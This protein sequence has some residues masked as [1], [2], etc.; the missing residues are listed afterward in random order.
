MNVDG[1]VA[2]ILAQPLPKG[3]L[4]AALPMYDWPE[5][6]RDVDAQWAPLRDALRARGVD[7]P[8]Q[9]ARCN[10]DLPAYHGA[11]AD[12]DPH[13]FDLGALWRHPGLL[14][15][16]ACYGP[17]ELWAGHAV[18]VVGQQDYSGV[19]GG[20]GALYRSAI[21]MRAGAYERDLCE[22]PPSVL[23]DISPTGGE[24]DNLL[25]LLSGKRLAYNAPDSM[26]GYLA[27][28]RDLVAQGAGLDIFAEQ[29]VSGGHRNSIRMVA[30]GAADV[31]AVDAKTWG[32][33]LKHEPM[34]RE[35]IVVGWTE[36]R[37]GLPYVTRAATRV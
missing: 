9:L 2:A 28:E 33:A 24:I 27:I 37:P 17:I 32:L 1:I 21:V 10:A 15:A 6:R 14:F 25:T 12:L 19:E 31:A 29:I 4:V 16:Q 26:S 30:S 13:E 22:A 20:D 5:E 34:S 36:K 11:S 7:A 8:E 23:S 3:P 35:L 18:R